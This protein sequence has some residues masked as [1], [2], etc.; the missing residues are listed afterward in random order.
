MRKSLS[1]QFSEVYTDRKADVYNA[2]HENK[3]KTRFYK[4][5]QTVTSEQLQVEEHCTFQPVINDDCPFISERTLRN[6]ANQQRR[7]RPPPPPPRSS[8][9]SPQKKRTPKFKVGGGVSEPNSGMYSKYT[10]FQRGPPMFADIPI[11]YFDP[12]APPSFETGKYTIVSSTTAPAGQ[13]ENLDVYEDMVVTDD[14][15]G[16]AS[17]TSTGLQAP[18][19]P[20]WAFTQGG[21]PS[22]AAVAKKPLLV[23]A[24]KKPKAEAEA[25]APTGWQAVLAEMAKKKEQMMGGGGA[26]KKVEPVKPKPEPEKKKKQK[27]KKGK[28]FKDVMDE[29]NY[30]LAKLRGEIVE[31]SDSDEESEE[32]KTIAT[33]PAKKPSSADSPTPSTDS[34]VPLETPPSEAPSTPKMKK[35]S[36]SF[37][38]EDAVEGESPAVMPK[39]KLPSKE[40]MMNLL[41]KVTKPPA[42]AATAAKEEEGS[43]A[44]SRAK[45]APNLG[46]MLAKKFA[47]TP[48]SDAAP[49]A[50]AVQ[51]PTVAG[52]VAVEKPSKVPA[53]PPIPSVWPPV[54]YTAV[55]PDAPAGKPAA[56]G[57]KVKKTKVIRKLVKKASGPPVP[58]TYG[59]TQQ[60]VLEDLPEGYYMA[61]PVIGMVAPRQIL[62]GGTTSLEL[63][64]SLQD[65]FKKAREMVEDKGPTSPQ[66]ETPYVKY[67]LS[68]AMSPFTPAD[69]KKTQFDDNDE[70]DAQAWKEHSPSQQIKDRLAVSDL[71]LPPDFHVAVQRMHQST[72]RR[73]ER[74]DKQR[75][76]ELRSFLYYDKSADKN[77]DPPTPGSTGKKLE[78]TVPVEFVS[79]T[80]QHLEKKAYSHRKP[81]PPL[82]AH[83]DPPLQDRIP[84]AY[85]C[86]SSVYQRSSSTDLVT[87]FWL[88]NLRPSV[89][90]PAPNAP[91]NNTSQMAKTASSR[92]QSHIPGAASPMVPPHYRTKTPGKAP[93]GPPSTVGSLANRAHAQSFLSPIALTTTMDASSDISSIDE[94]HLTPGARYYMNYRPQTEPKAPKMRSE[95]LIN[96]RQSERK[97]RE[98]RRLQQ[99]KE[100]EEK[101]KQRK[102]QIK[103]KAMQAAQEAGTYRP[104]SRYHTHQKIFDKYSHNPDVGL[105]VERAAKGAYAEYTARHHLP[106]S[107]SDMLYASAQKKAAAANRQHQLE[108]SRMEDLQR[109]F[110]DYDD[111]QRNPH[112]QYNGY[113]YDQQQ[114][115]YS[116]AP[117]RNLLQYHY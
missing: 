2:L 88:N 52:K 84:S 85:K 25:P 87:T 73:E 40:S 27:K 82:P 68:L 24:P 70:Y 6:F 92:A 46:A 117:Q 50:S 47:A 28:D 112:Q 12:I 7:R 111:G 35:A 90:S 56:G 78:I 18:P 55:E 110:E 115:P 79:H 116:P 13:S 5:T 49:T 71:P 45:S 1:A 104:N 38:A 69:E 54:P 41:S 19:L 9:M 43:S 64:T 59:T 96:R 74:L 80:D 22:N 26:L 77:T 106:P 108:M 44:V 63:L 61:A 99:E 29:L 113:V 105:N 31:E 66:P 101:I 4:T 20:D 10:G 103:M 3:K 114:S 86:P 97:L 107:E 98:E 75:D 32:V 94:N 15:G 102:L 42:A 23:F 34:P 60:N 100:E 83:L 33:G 67:D 8:S 17:T 39:H 53:P 51:P 14:E 109:E 72:Q 95:E 37:A 93:S 48:T 62:A 58:V 76:L 89:N 30:K 81:A 21:A 36:I 57:D 16:E 91:H 65:T 11:Y